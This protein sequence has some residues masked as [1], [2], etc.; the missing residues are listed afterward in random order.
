MSNRSFTHDA[1]EFLDNVIDNQRQIITDM[2][3]DLA[4]QETVSGEIIVTKEIMSDAIRRYFK[5]RI[6]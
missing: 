1:L 5:G 3:L 6:V 2:S 4:E